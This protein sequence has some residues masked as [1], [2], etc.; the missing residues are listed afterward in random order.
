MSK[1]IDINP[2]DINSKRNALIEDLSLQ[3][4]N[5]CY[6]FA[7]IHDDWL[8][9]IY[10]QNLAQY[11]G[12][13]LVA[14]GGYGRAEMAPK[15]DLDLVLLHD[16]TRS[17]S[18]LAE[19][20]KLAWHPIWDANLRLGNA[21]R[22]T[23]ESLELAKTDRDTA[24]AILNT[25]FLAGDR[26]LALQLSTRAKSEW[27]HNRRNSIEM[28]AEAIDHRRE[29]NGQLAFL[30]EPD[31]KVS[32]GGLRDIHTMD[33]LEQAGV[34]VL[35]I[36]RHDIEQARETLLGARVALHRV[37]LH[38]SDRF[39][40]QDQDAAAEIL[41]WGDADDVMSRVAAAA[42]SVTWTRRAVVRRGRRRITP[43]V[44][45]QPPRASLRPL[46]QGLEIRDEAI[47]LADDAD[48]ENDETLILRMAIAAASHELYVNRHSLEQLAR[49]ARVP[50]RPWSRGVRDLFV[51]LLMCGPGAVSA[52]ETLDHVGLFVQLLPEWEPNQAKVQRNQYHRFTV[53]RHLLMATANAA[54][55]VRESKHIRRF[56][57]LVTAALLHDIGKGYPG[58]H[59]EVGVKLIAEI[60]PNMG[61]NAEETRV[62]QRLCQHHLLLSDV[63][64]RRDIEDEGTIALVAAAVETVEFIDLLE[65]LTEADSLATGPSAWSRWKANLI[66]RLVWGTKQYLSTGKSGLKSAF[67]S[68]QQL[69]MVK[70][71]QP[72]IFGHHDTFTVIE[73]D[74]IGLFARVA[75]VLALSGLNI[76]S[77]NTFSDSVFVIEETKVEVEAGKTIDWEPIEKLAAEL[78]ASTQ[79]LAPKIAQRQAEMLF[80]PKPAPNRLVTT[81]VLIDTELAESSTIIEVAALD[82]PGLLYEIAQAIADAG[83]TNEQTHI[84]TIGDDVVDAFYVKHASGKKVTESSVLEPLRQRLEQIIQDR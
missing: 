3:G 24:T 35:A 75:G 69:E 4:G 62:L 14:V 55:I 56:D 34:R 63:A 81:R 67:P 23:E 57:L 83:L 10:Q 41:G 38:K 65:A 31:L 11:S 18:D 27:K 7:Q 49:N 22:T 21:L 13:A 5:F 1:P 39:T 59:T 33:W 72:R 50:K 2:I 40:F 48:L 54:T 45:Q 78:I 44:H 37:N 36:E 73:K 51:Q 25:R 60:A 43:L 28:M 19:I 53:D 30:L 74:R 6:E 47:S 80:S 52:I 15:S 16:G 8:I 42:R 9:E 58:D 77:A 61:F 79:D 32:A 76:V 64:T 71:Q 17:E 46:G 84:H 68:E 66:H 26:N 20:A 82:R 29:N 12:I 70:A